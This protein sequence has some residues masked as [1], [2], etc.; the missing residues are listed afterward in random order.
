MT[1]TGCI[2][3]VHLLRSSSP[4]LDMMGMEAVA[5]W[6]YRPARLNGRPV[7]VYLTVTVTY[8]LGR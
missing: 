5:Q 7:R 1:E 3:N 4:E 8:R 2:T 6:R